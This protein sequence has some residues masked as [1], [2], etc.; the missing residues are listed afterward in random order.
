MYL[1][2]PD[3]LWSVEMRFLLYSPDSFGLGHIR[4]SLAVAARLHAA[5]PGSTVRLLTGAPRAHFFEYPADTDYV[6]L[7]AIT[8]DADGRYVPRNPEATITETLR[9]RSDLIVHTVERFRPDVWLIDHAPTGLCDELLP[10]LEQS[11]RV[12]GRLH[13]LGLRDV[14]D[15]PERVRHAWRSDGTAATIERLYDRVLVYGHRRVL[16]VVEAYGLEPTLASRV[17]YAGYIDRPRT[18][19]NRSAIRRLLAPRTE[20]LV[21]VTLGGGGD[22]D[23][24]LRTFYAGHRSLGARPA[25][26]SLAVT[27]PLMSPDKRR[28][29]RRT[30]AGLD[31][32]VQLDFTPALTDL[33]AAADLVVSMGGYN[34]ICELA[35][36]GA[37]ALVVPRKS[38]R[39][40]QWFR[41]ER[42]AAL[43]AITLLDPDTLTP[44][45]L[46]EAIVTG[47]GARATPHDWKLQL[48]GLDAMVAEIAEHFSGE[49]HEKLS[50][51]LP[52]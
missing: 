44:A 12:P 10:G 34:T 14:I 27:G 1:D 22:G 32:V 35:A 21:L 43:G 23:R 16:D 48:G 28:R 11:R 19:G 51:S 46:I 40:E 15:E 9:M 2:G 3:R 6:A 47:I 37:N 25:F 45:T 13:V 31:R 49:M 8:K 20:R 18:H 17:R 29:L 42:L 7:P 26:E 33:M 4:R 38:P 30:A 50:P 36:V 5:F 41:A 24:L 39:R 52:G